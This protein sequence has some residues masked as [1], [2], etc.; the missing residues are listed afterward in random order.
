HRVT[1]L[2]EIESRHQAAFSI[3]KIFF[4]NSTVVIVIAQLPSNLLR[5]IKLSAYR[6]RKSQRVAITDHNHR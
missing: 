6:V 2:A 1:L 3:I 4:N 5:K